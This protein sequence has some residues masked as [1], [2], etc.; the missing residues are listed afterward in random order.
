M[1]KKKLY[2]DITDFYATDFLTGIQR[3]VREVVVRLLK[4]EEFEVVLFSWLN[5]EDELCVLSNDDFLKCYDEDS[6]KKSKIRIVKR[7]FPADLEKGGVLFDVDAVWNGNCHPRFDVLS[8]L[9]KQGVLISA[10]V[11]DVLPIT[12]PEFFGAS[13]PGFYSYIA[14]NLCYADC[15]IASTQVTV[16]KL[17]NLANRYG[18]PT[19]CCSVS[20]LGSDF[21]SKRKAEGVSKKAQN[22]ASKGKYILCVG[23]LEPRKNHKLVLDAYDRKLSKIGLNLVF[24]GRRGWC[25]DDFLARVDNHPKKDKGFYFLEGENDA[26]I[27]YLY[28][29]AWAVVFPTFDEGFG[30]PLVEALLHGCPCVASDVP[31]MREVGGSFCDYV[32]PESSESLEE[33]LLGYF[34][35]PEKYEN[36][37]RRANEF[38]P[39]LWDDV[40]ERIKGDLLNLRRNDKQK[41]GAAQ[42]DA[43]Q[44][45]DGI[46]E[47]VVRKVFVSQTFEAIPLIDSEKY[48]PKKGLKN[49][50]KRAIRK[51]VRFYIS[52]IVHDINDRIALQNAILRNQ[53]YAIK[54]LL[55]TIDG[56]KTQG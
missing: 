46:Y 17:M 31:V 10:F 6:L 56:Q 35:T 3:V 27:D 15:L 45:M 22:I 43:N 16:D 51:C 23:T 11:H 44:V 1:T 42:I 53:N 36:L 7:I 47:D 50:F 4:M 28:Q 30:L 14:A 34:E 19:P 25:V 21:K 49:F 9:S 52:P 20:W 41:D 12:N 29:N 13:V 54:Q 24:A 38:K 26:T 18:A 48:I 37:K 2:I 8:R 55:K 32:N 5:T 39:F 33:T 40:A